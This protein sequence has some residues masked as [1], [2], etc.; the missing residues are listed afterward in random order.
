[1]IS[2]A[3]LA[4]SMVQSGQADPWAEF[5]PV[6]P[7]PP[8]YVLEPPCPGGRSDCQPWERHS[9]ADPSKR[10]NVFDKFDEAPLNFGPGP[11]TLVLTMGVHITRMDYKSGQDC[12]RARATALRQ[13]GARRNPD[14]SITV[15]SGNAICIP[16]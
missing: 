11:H 14:G 8:G 13:M 2:A 5:N 1:M 7:P 10:G 3:L 4:V 16:R 12:Q 9:S 15:S 6:P